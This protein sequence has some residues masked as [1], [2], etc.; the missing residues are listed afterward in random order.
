MPFVSVTWLV[1]QLFS[2]WLNAFADKNMKRI[3]VTWPV[4]HLCSG[5]L[6]A[7]ANENMPC[8]LVTLCVFQ[9]FSGSLN[10]SP[11][12][13]NKRFMLVTLVVSQLDMCPY[14]ALALSGSSSHSVT[15][16]RSVLSSNWEGGVA[17]PA[18][19]PTRPV[20]RPRVLV[21]EMRMPF[22]IYSWFEITPK[23]TTFESRNKCRVSVRHTYILCSPNDD[24][25]DG[26]DDEIRMFEELFKGAW[27]LDFGYETLNRQSKLRSSSFV[28]H[29]RIFVWGS[30]RLATCCWVHLP[31]QF[32]S[33]P[34]I[35]ELGRPNKRNLSECV[36]EALFNDSSPYT[37][38][39]AKHS[40]SFVRPSKIVFWGDTCFK[41]RLQRACR[42]NKMMIDEHL[43][44]LFCQE[45][46]CVH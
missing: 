35:L 29:S 44:K 34:K 45:G 6:N 24:L 3:S 41:W 20:H 19:D 27:V 13:W 30:M 14:F 17:P 10:W 38:K 46:A 12:F 22:V 23:E 18:T 42:H 5:W 43:I 7:L 4:S 11:F 33:Q 36:F 15:A 40:E 28:T 39:S 21:G 9:S 2:G 32:D 37:A 25:E 31:S 16:I 26:T 8:M 1:F